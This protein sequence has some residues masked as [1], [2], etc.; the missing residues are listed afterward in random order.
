MRIT[1][2]GTFTTQLTRFPRIFP[3]NCYLVREDDGFTLVDTA[4]SGSAPAIIAAARM[5]GAPITRI[6]LTHAHGDHV[7]SLD[8]LHTLL[9]EAAVLIGARDARFLRGDMRLDPDE[10]QDKLRGGFPRCTTRPTRELR[11]GDRV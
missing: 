2:H 1:P 4:I 11:P 9:P 3:V 6:A 5:L 8:A 10:P 7:G